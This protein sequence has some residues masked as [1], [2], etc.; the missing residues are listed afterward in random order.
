M[1]QSANVCKF[2]LDFGPS[3]SKLRKITHIE[4]ENKKGFIRNSSILWPNIVSQ[5]RNVT[6]PS[7]FLNDCHVKTEA[8]IN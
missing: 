4:I 3:L 7:T 1:V 6:L 8:I 2:C 5:Y